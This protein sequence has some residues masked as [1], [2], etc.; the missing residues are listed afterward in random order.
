MYDQLEEKARHPKCADAIE[1]GSSFGKF[2]RLNKNKFV[3]IYDE[4]TNE[5]GLQ[6]FLGNRKKSSGSFIVRIIR[7]KPEG[8]FLASWKQN[9]ISLITRNLNGNQFIELNKK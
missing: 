4:K 1:F 3:M 9:R 8:I 2:S 6:Y 5:E 7:P